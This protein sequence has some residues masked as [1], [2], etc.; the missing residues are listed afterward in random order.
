MLL[1]S[2]SVNQH[3]FI[4]LSIV[5]AS[6]H[7]RWSSTCRR[8]GPLYQPIWFK[9]CRPNLLRHPCLH[10][11]SI[12]SPMGHSMCCHLILSTHHYFCSQICMRCH[13]LILL[14]NPSYHLGVGSLQIHSTFKVDEY[15]AHSNPNVFFGY[16]SPITGRDLTAYCRL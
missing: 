16:C 10:M 1:P 3:D 15:S 14:A 11:R 12:M 13:P 7:H 4:T 6:M 8:L 5:C 2:D 9:S